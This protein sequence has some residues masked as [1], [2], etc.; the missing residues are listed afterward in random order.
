MR[1]TSAIISIDKLTEDAVA[2]LTAALKLVP[3]VQSVDFSLERSVA[4]VEFD[5]GEAK[6]DD[7]LRAVQKAGYR[8]V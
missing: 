6:V 5:G 2:P 1:T 7:F 3:G 8:V 4:V